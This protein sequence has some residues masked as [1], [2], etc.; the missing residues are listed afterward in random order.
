[1]QQRWRELEFHT[2]QGSR[3]KG[4]HVPEKFASSSRWM[5]AAAIAAAHVVLIRRADVEFFAHPQVSSPAVE[6]IMAGRFI[7]QSVDWDTSPFP[8]V[9]LKTIGV[10][11]DALQVIRFDEGDAD[12]LSGIIGATSA[13][14]PHRIQS[15][16]IQQYAQ[17][18]QVRP[19]QPAT[20]V[21]SIE[22]QPD[23]TVRSTTV[24]RSCGDRRVDILAMDYAR[25][26]IWFPGTVG[27]QPQTMRVVYPVTFVVPSVAARRS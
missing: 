4:I 11:Q 27:Q 1:V 8:E 17:R 13:P 6:P 2:T 24:I 12:W 20:V 18:A 7:V 22:V 26:L 15:V 9:D 10:D 5:F 23:G 14:R 16:D 19:G 25:R 21:L 3:P